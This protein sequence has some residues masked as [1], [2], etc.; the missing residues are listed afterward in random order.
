MV[1]WYNE[2]QGQKEVG[3]QENTTNQQ[4]ATR[5]LFFYLLSL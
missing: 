5:R 4:P 3:K 1:Y 2:W